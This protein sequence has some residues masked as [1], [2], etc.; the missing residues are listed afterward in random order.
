MYGDNGRPS[1][2]LLKAAAE[3]DC[4]DKGGVTF[5]DWESV[6]PL[7][8]PLVRE[9][10]S[11]L[12]EKQIMAVVNQ[13]AQWIEEIDEDLFVVEFE[14]DQDEESS[15]TNDHSA[16]D[17]SDS[18]DSGS[19][20]EAA[21]SES[22]AASSESTGSEAEENHGEETEATETETP[23]ADS[24]SRSKNQSDESA[25]GSEEEK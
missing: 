22:E 13:D 3:K 1:S 12:D 16:E 9:F 10:V 23:Q 24:D 5:D 2:R 15:K 7:K 14:D 21:S 8:I 6:G 4:D 11:G 25:P 17:D 20:S 19:E 18:G